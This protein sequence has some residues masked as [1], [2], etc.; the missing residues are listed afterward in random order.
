L[1]AAPRTCLARVHDFLGTGKALTPAYWA[2]IESLGLC[3]AAPDWLA[4]MPADERDRIEAVQ[5][6]TLRRWRFG[7][8]A[9]GPAF[10][11]LP[12]ASAAG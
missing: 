9:G 7:D 4:R 2:F 8:M 5:H 6:A 10:P 12:V 3:P 1:L 11:A